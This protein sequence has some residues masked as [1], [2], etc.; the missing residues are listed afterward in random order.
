[1]RVM[2][3]L[4]GWVRSWVCSNQR[5]SRASA[6]CTALQAAICCASTQSTSVYLAMISLMLSLRKVA[7][8]KASAEIREKVPAPTEGLTL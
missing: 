8:S 5:A 4:L 1:V 3:A 2:D 7:R 6:S